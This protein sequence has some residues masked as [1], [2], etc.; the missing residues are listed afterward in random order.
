MIEGI[1]MTDS[2]GMLWS[3][4]AGA[5]L[6]GLYLFGLWLTVR[7]I[8]QG[9]LSG[10]WL[11]ASMFVRLVLVLTAFYLILG[12][13]RWPRLLAA[14]AGF[15]VLRIVATRRVQQRISSTTGTRESSS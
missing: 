7:G 11:P 9:R 10:W 2:P 8:S 4:A 1:T 6:G 3:F 13:A 15:V 12:D 5:L 14:L